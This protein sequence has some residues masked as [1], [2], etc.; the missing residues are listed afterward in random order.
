MK[1]LEVKEFIES[2]PKN[3]LVEYLTDVG[4]DPKNLSAEPVVQRLDIEA[5]F[6]PEGNG[7]YS[8]C[9]LEILERDDNQAYRVYSFF[10]FD[11]YENEREELAYEVFKMMKEFA[12]KQMMEE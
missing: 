10:D 3:P 11:C 6:N 1:Y 8:R 5:N 7:S 9:F 2:L 4:I 12:G